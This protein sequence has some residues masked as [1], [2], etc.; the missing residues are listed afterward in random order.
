[1]DQMR[2]RETRGREV[3]VWAIVQAKQITQNEYKAFVENMNC[4][5][6]Q[7]LHAV[8]AYGVAVHQG[9][10]DVVKNMKPVVQELLK[11]CDRVVDEGR[12]INSALAE[13]LEA[14]KKVL[15]RILKIIPTGGTIHIQKV[16]KELQDFPGIIINVLAWGDGL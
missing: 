8:G 12:L 14:N 9:A 10:R 7:A 4:T 13:V 2:Y 3:S 15:T 5:F 6:E 11:S 16:K 1:M